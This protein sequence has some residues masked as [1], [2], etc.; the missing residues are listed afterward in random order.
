MTVV[1]NTE[2]ERAD[3]QAL[4]SNLDSASMRI[5]VSILLLFF[6]TISF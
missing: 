4:Q 6:I 1:V 2:A 5:N 3:I